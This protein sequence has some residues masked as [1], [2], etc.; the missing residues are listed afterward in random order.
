M[1]AS[2]KRS[3]LIDVISRSFRA[4]WGV[5][6]LVLKR[7]PLPLAV[8]AFT[9]ALMLAL[10]TKL[11]FASQGLMM[12]PALFVEGLFLAYVL[13]LV[14]LNEPFPCALTGDPEADR[15]RIAEQKRV[16]KG[17]AGMYALIMML[18]N[19]VAIALTE[20]PGM[21]EAMDG[22]AG[23]QGL[24][25]IGAV[26]TQTLKD[27][28]PQI[29]PAVAF[30]SSAVAMLLLAATLWAVRY[31]CL[32]V[33]VALGVRLKAYLKAGR[34]FSLSIHMIILGLICFFPVYIGFSLP[35]GVAWGMI[36]GQLPSWSMSYVAGVSVFS[37]VQSA[38]QLCFSVLFSVAFGQLMLGIM[39]RKREGR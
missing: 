1:Q 38:M 19:G 7:A 25:D 2:P 20:L 37:V 18:M 14:L 8:K 39:A 5:R 13:R 36:E 23:S 4:L 28:M 9:L 35:Q 15:L 26:H 27:A 30:V 10:G 17:T 24:N 11:S 29:P 12:V 22:M 6:F 32:Y 16:I 33:P 21:R 31:V 3:D 34:G